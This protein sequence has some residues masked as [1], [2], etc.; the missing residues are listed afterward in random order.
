MKMG[1]LFDLAF[2][3]D[4]LYFDILWLE[5]GTQL[6]KN[7]YYTIPPGTMGSRKSCS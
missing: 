3:L 1:V 5:S 2:P 6:A 4:E 7:A